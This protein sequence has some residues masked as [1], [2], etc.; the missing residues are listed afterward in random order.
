MLFIPNG[1]ANDEIAQSIRKESDTRKIV[2]AGN[3]GLA[4]NTEL[5]N[6]LVPLLAD[7]DTRLTIIGYGV[8]KNQ[9]LESVKN[10][11]NVQFIK[12]MTKKQCLKVIA[13]HDLGLVTLKDKEVFKTVLPGKIIDY[14][15]CGVPVIGVL[16]GYA[17]EL[18]ESEKVGVAMNDSDP[19]AIFSQIKRLLEDRH[20]REEMAQNALELTYEK[21]N[22]ETNIYSLLEYMDDSILI[23]QRNDCEDV[24]EGLHVRL[25]SLHK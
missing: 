22:F 9:V 5:I 11:K 7:Y 8:N 25:E 13:D 1:V 17:K 10:H 19:Q 3:L 24:K 2:Y 14:L 15:A 23:E 18:I 12:P 20:L 6:Q 21:F 16:D 4:Q